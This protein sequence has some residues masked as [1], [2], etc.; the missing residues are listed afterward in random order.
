MDNIPSNKYAGPGIL[1]VLGLGVQLS[2]YTNPS[3]G[4]ALIAVAVIWAAI[5]YLDVWSRAFGWLGGSRLRRAEREVARIKGDPGLL[6]F[7]DELT[8]TGKGF[9]RKTIGWLMYPHGGFAPI[10]EPT[11]E[12]EREK[13]CAK[14]LLKR[15]YMQRATDQANPY[16][17]TFFPTDWAFAIKRLTKRRSPR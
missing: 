7:L 8:D 6:S 17:T 9:P 5:A 14:Y 4:L 3:L 10:G 15:G 16:G 1:A 11:L 13:E 2:G 12:D